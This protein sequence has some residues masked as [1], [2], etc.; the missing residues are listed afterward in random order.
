M[1]RST[2]IHIIYID[3]AGKSTLHLDCRDGYAMP[4]KGV[5]QDAHAAQGPFVDHMPY[6]AETTTA[7]TSGTTLRAR[8]VFHDLSSSSAGT[9]RLMATRATLKA[10]TYQG[11]CANKGWGLCSFC[12]G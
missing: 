11:D 3:N 8:E 7:A 12:W 9:K 10:M 2:P 4:L 1:E 5:P 6:P